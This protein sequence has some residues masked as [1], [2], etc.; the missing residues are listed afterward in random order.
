MRIGCIFI[1]VLLLIIHM[2]NASEKRNLL[3]Q[4]GNTGLLKSS[5]VLYLEW[6]PYP[7]YKNRIGWDVLTTGVKDEIIKKG[8]S[9]PKFVWRNEIYPLSLTSRKLLLSG[10]YK[11]P[12]VKM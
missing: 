9:A 3:Q 2:A 12:V 4:M 8:E 6:V 7:G 1:A 11:I 10:K 5:L